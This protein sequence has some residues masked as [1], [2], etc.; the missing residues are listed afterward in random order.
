MVHSMTAFAREEISAEWGTAAWELR[1]VNHRYLD[2]SL[3]LPEEL[4]SLDAGVRGRI[5]ARVRRGKVDCSL[6]VQPAAGGGAG[7]SL[8]L[9][10]A[11][12]LLDAKRK[13]EA[14]GRRIPGGLPLRSPTALDVLRWP[15][16]AEPQGIDRESVGGAALR[17]L[18]RALDTLVAA[19]A[20]EGAKLG[21]MVAGRCE[22]VE[23]IAARVRAALPDVQERYRA[24]LVAR[25]DEARV[26]I[27]PNRLAQEL[28]MF[29]SRTDVAEELDRLD[30]H[31]TEVRG[32]LGS[33]SPI[34]RRLDFLMQ[35][36]QREA[37]TLGSKSAD[38]DTSRASVDLKVLIEQMREQV[39]NIE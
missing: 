4:R 7:F 15:G 3:R 30:T 33:G 36:L 34:G 24:R 19:R 6:R 32:A 29:A 22:E 21:D 5:A 38:P 39:Q 13:V 37:N 35:E 9:D 10:L 31:V 25:L 11:K 16:V 18:D 27:D 8:D 28:V 26:D 2:V 23:S 20:R 17:L 12:R 1:S 14:A